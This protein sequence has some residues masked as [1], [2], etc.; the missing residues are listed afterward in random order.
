[1]DFFALRCFVEIV[2]SGGFTRASEALGRTQPAVSFQIRKLEE[3][4]GGPLIDRST[5][6]LAMTDRGR[7]LFPRA[8]RILEELADLGRE[9]ASEGDFPR[10]RVTIAAGIAVIEGFLPALLGAFKSSYPNI[11][12]A[13]LNRPD[14]GIYRSLIDGRADLGIGY[15]LGGRPR[16]ASE[17]IGELRFFLVSRKGRDGR[18]PA[19]DELLAL[20]LLS[21]EKGFDL[22]NYLEGRLGPLATSLEL[23]SAEALLRYA[24]RGVGPAIVPVIGEAPDRPALEWASLD[25][26]VPPL[27]LELYF[28][29]GAVASKAAA[30]LAR[31]IREGKS[32]DEIA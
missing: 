17:Q 4:L 23:P 27:P 16:I 20:P 9:I 13:L 31:T 1:M 8:E 19:V 26:R 28:R 10:G 7:Q 25:D 14:E 5:P 2:R 30:L 29:E 32:A 22:R 21:F 6:A 12:L 18:P 11:R 24:E 15:L 3:E